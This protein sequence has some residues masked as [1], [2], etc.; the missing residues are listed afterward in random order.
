MQQ[1]ARILKQQRM[2]CSVVRLA[3]A[4][5]YLSAVAD[6]FGL[7]GGPG[8]PGVVWGAMAPFLA[9]TAQVNSFL[10]A[11]MAPFLG[12]TATV[13]EV[14]LALALSAGVRVRLTAAASGALLLS[15]AVAMMISFGIKAPL[16]YSVF[17]GAAAS[18]LLAAFSPP[19]TGRASAD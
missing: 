12:W 17:T 1:E 6:R 14:G 11:S 5:T 9:Y 2:A 4:A 19:D 3:L 16:D 13:F 18:F 7:W 15:F 8:T 10:P